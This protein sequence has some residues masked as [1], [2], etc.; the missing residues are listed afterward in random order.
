MKRQLKI[1]GF[2]VVLCVGAAV[3]IWI[4]TLGWNYDLESWWIVANLVNEGQNVYVHTFRLPYGPV[5]AGIAWLLLRIEYFLGFTGIPAF[6]LLVSSFLTSIDTGIILTLVSARR[7]LPGVLFALCPVSVLITGYHSQID[8]IAILFGL[9][10]WRLLDKGTAEGAAR[11]GIVSSAVL[12][13]GS[14]ATKHIFAFFPLWVLCWPAVPLRRRLLYAVL[15]YGTFL[16]SVLPF[17]LSPAG[18]AGLKSHVFLY[19][20]SGWFGNGLVPRILHYASLNRGALVA[21]A[22]G[23]GMIGAGVIIA[24]WAPRELFFLHPVAIVTLTPTLADQHLTIPVISFAEYSQSILLWAYVLMATTALIASTNG[25]GSVGSM[26]FI[27]ALLRSKGLNL[28]P[29]VQST[30]LP[31]VVLLLFFASLPIKYALGKQIRRGASSS[32]S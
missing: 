21:L 25:V 12:M 20:G 27:A 2:G 19:R 9:W 8:N 29:S 14:L 23:L 15:A 30:I 26:Q 4:S 10:S 6:H 5:W 3:R 11:F 22:F 7:Y 28:S 17:A 32:E 16:C 24:R 1:V 31:Q 18:L 13:G